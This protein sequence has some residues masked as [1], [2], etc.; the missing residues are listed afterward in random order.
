MSTVE[1]RTRYTP[2]DLLRMP[3]GDRYELIDGQLVEPNVSTWASYVAGRIERRLG[4][5][6]EDKQL[7]WVFPEG[8]CYQCFPDSPEMVRKADVSFIRRERLTFAEAQAEGHTH[9][10]PDLAVE[11]V[12]PND[13]MYEVDGKVRLYLQAGV[14]LVWVVNPATHTVQVHRPQVQGIILHENDE[15]TCEEM[16]PGFHCRVGDLF[17]PP[18]GI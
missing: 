11:V 12:S 16:L 8:T 4:N 14:R 5:Y 10:A 13:T 18:P 3:D 17:Q 9:I 6:C 15:L 7:G 1:A 2:E